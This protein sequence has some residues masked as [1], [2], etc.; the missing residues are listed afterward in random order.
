MSENHD[1]LRH[2]LDRLFTQQVNRPVLEAA[3]A[4]TFPTALWSALEEAGLT[5]PMVPA[6]Q[7]GAG[8]TAFDA[9][10]IVRAAGSH[11]A[12]V[13]LPETMLAG[14][15]LWA[16]GLK[17]PA[18][19]LSIAPVRPEENLT[20]SAN[21]G[22]GF[23]LDGRVTRIPWGRDARAL[24]VLATAPDG[25]KVVLVEPG[26][27]ALTPARNLAGE[28]R[29]TLTFTGLAVKPGQVAPAPAG[30]DGA[31]LHLRG[32]VMRS[33]QMAGALERSLDF[34]VRYAGERS[35]FGRPIGRFQAVQ[36][37]LAIFA[38]QTAAAGRAVDAAFEALAAGGDIAF[39]G[40]IAKARVGEAAGQGAAIAH[41]VHGA[42][43]FTR[44]HALH[45]GTRRLWSWRDE[46]GAESYWQ[47]ALGRRI[48]AAGA[49]AFW[50]L[51]TGTA[52]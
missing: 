42:M 49:E 37:Q 41:Q 45:Y 5:L 31:A 26:G 21:A 48:A 32:A 9:L 30:V 13:P 2:S 22:G 47:E 43:G 39:V 34:T 28:P 10:A 14:W 12:P 50:P 25:L 7:G 6:E 19:P 20:L 16:C 24:A 3:E 44:E 17:I 38:G 51:L 35:Q 15:L 52:D 18:G 36:Q 46:F 33:A 29:D 8:G 4:G 40:A 1:L 23:R 27:F 11:A